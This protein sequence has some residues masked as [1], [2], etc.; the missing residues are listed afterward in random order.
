MIL[1][2]FNLCRRILEV[3]FFAGLAGCILVISLSWIS[4]FTDGFSADQD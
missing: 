4:I 2:V 1:F 3:V